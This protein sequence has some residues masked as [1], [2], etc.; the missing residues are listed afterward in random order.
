M[1]KLGKIMCVED[2]ADIQTVAKMALE[3]VGGFDVEMCGSGEEALKKSA[4]IPA[5]FNFARRYDARYG[6]ARD[7]SCRPQAAG[8]RSDADRVLDGEKPGA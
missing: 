1:K 6:R 8:S 7:L 5:R 4:K 2:E 3:I